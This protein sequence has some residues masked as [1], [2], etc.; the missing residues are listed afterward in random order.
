MK[1]ILP[2]ILIVVL[3]G[4]KEVSFQEPQPK[5]KKPLT[6]VP[7][8]L[9]GKYLAKTAEGELAK[10]TIVITERGYRFAYFDPAERK[11]QNKSYEEGLLGDSL[12][13]THFK[14]YYFVNLNEDPEWILRILKPEK[15]GDLIYMTL[16][17]PGTDFNIYLEKLSSQIRIDSITTEKETLYQINPSPAELISLIEKGYTSKTLLVRI[18]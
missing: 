8:Q 4:C 3:V 2:A 16:D 17:E 14:G 18:R 9:R 13:L 6:S 5:G 10:D 11:I 15:N 7:K 12:V 1:R